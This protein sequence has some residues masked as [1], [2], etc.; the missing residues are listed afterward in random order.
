MN[1]KDRYLTARATKGVKR[2]TQASEGSAACCC[3][4]TTP[5]AKASTAQV[6]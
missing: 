4:R 3:R 5:A 6:I 2:K 1:H